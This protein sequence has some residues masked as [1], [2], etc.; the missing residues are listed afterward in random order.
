MLAVNRVSG[1]QEAKT[2]GSYTV[3]SGLPEYSWRDL[4]RGAPYLSLHLIS[5]A[6]GDPLPLFVSDHRGM[7]TP[8]DPSYLAPFRTPHLERK[9]GANSVSGVHP[10][11][12]STWP[13]VRKVS[14]TLRQ[15]GGARSAFLIPSYTRNCWRTQRPEKEQKSHIPGYFRQD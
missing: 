9:R 3:V 1:L 12:S 11:R 8:R 5:Q 2:G 4:T 15:R 7:S 13:Q 6:A 10:L 14:S